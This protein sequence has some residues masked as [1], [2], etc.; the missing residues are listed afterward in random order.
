[1]DSNIFT[2]HKRVQILNKRILTYSLFIT[3]KVT[4]IFVTTPQ[5]TIARVRARAQE[6]TTTVQLRNS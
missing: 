4:E 6:P 5:C 1:M 3:A 2:V